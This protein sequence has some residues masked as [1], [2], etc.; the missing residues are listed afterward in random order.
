MISSLAHHFVPSS[1][2]NN[3]THLVT[4]LNDLFTYKDYHFVPSS[5]LNNPTHL[6]TSLNDLFTYKDYISDIQVFI[7]KFSSKKNGQLP[8]RHL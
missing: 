2:L 3:P 5:F 4:S 1:F 7:C 6:V 8:T